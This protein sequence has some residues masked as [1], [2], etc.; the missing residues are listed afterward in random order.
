MM[1]ELIANIFRDIL[2]RDWLQDDDIYPISENF[3]KIEELLKDDHMSFIS[4][5]RKGDEGRNY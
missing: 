4:G 1:I 5:A 2:K 3:V